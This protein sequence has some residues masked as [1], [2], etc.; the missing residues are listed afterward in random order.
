MK[1]VTIA[2]HYEQMDKLG[3]LSVTRSFIQAVLYEAYARDDQ[4]QVEEFSAKL[5]QVEKEIDEL[6]E[7]L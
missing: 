1:P 4:E 6:M 2:Q 5:A 3:S 7:E